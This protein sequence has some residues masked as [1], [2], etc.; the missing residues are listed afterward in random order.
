LNTTLES[1]L[2][3]VLSELLATRI[4]SFEKL[5]IVIALHSAP[6]TKLSTDELCRALELSREAVRE[7]TAELHAVSLVELSE[8]GDVTLLSRDD[9]QAICD[10]VRLYADDRFTV[11]KA[12][13]E[14]AVERIRRI[15][16]R[17]FVIRKGA[18]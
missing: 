10:L 11:V 1:K 14:I 13:G 4:D 15:A 9:E 12:M 17:T 5:E 18:R 2:S 8:Q 6:G 16:S 3:D 7:A